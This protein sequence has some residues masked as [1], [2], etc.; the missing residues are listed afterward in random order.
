MR[1][2]EQSHVERLLER[3]AETEAHQGFSGVASS[4]AARATI[5]AASC[6]GIAAQVRGN[7]QSLAPAHRQIDDDGVGMKNFP[8]ACRPRSRC[9][10]THI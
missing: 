1:L 9:W 10:R 6:A 5:I 4:S 8:P 3:F 2:A 7:R